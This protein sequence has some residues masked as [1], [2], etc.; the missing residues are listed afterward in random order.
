MAADN[1]TSKRIDIEEEIM[2]SHRSTH[3]FCYYGG[4]TLN[5][6]PGGMCLQSKYEAHPGD[7]LCLRLIGNHLQTFTSLDELT[8]IAEVRW[9][10]TTGTP[11]QPVY[12]IGLHYHGNLVPPLFKPQE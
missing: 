8:C 12:R 3:P 9:C 6:S 11:D 5:H 2:F 10:E 4:A 1:R 7:R